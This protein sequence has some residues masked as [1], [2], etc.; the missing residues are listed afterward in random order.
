MARTMLEIDRVETLKVLEE[1]LVVWE[2]EKADYDA[3]EADNQAKRK[4][5]DTLDEVWKRKAAEYI[6]KNIDFDDPDLISLGYRNDS[7][8][9]NVRHLSVK[10]I[11]AAI[12]K[13]PELKIEHVVQ[14]DCLRWDDG[15]T[16]I[17]RLRNAIQMLKLSSQATV[18]GSLAKNAFDLL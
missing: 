14:P 4:E 7:V 16:N 2:K 11:E 5:F 6:V 3:I 9:L 17:E 8:T 13:K 12:G 1:K 15:K 18:S 10:Q